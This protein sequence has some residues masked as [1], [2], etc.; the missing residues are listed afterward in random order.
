MREENSS[1]RKQKILLWEG[2]LG[3]NIAVLEDFAQLLQ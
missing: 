3:V 2:M 1:E